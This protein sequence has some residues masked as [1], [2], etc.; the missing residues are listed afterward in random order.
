MVK[1][2]EVR[3][4]GDYVD[5]LINKRIVYY[6]GDD[7][8]TI[9]KFDI[10]KI[11]YKCIDEVNKFEQLVDKEKIDITEDNYWKNYVKDCVENV[12]IKYGRNRNIKRIR[13]N[14]FRG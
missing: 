4:E 11:W 2:G 13:F 3:D 9:N 1:Y 5:Y 7:E 8:K 10:E 6:Y 12:L 14:I